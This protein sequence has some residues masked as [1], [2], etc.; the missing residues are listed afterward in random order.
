[1]AALRELAGGRSDLLAEVAGIFEGASEGELDEPL[2][3]QAAG[4]Y[5]KARGRSG[6]D[7]GW[8][9]EGWRRRDAAGR[10]SFSGGPHG[11]GTR[12]P[13]LGKVSGGRSSARSPALA[14]EVLQ[15]VGVRLPLHRPTRG[16]YRVVSGSHSLCTIGPCRASPD[17]KSAA[18]GAVPGRNHDLGHH[19]ALRPRR[20]PTDRYNNTIAKPVAFSNYAAVTPAAD[21]GRLSGLFPDGRAPMW[22]WCP[23]WDVNVREYRKVQVGD[24]VMLGRQGRYFP[25]GT[26]AYVLHNAELAEARGAGT[27]MIRP[28]NTCMRWTRSDP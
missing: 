19:A 14:A 7:T 25:C 5:R 13:G 21:F 24:L 1:V 16:A 8:I 28:G 27:S 11:G 3:R 20:A 23:E 12:P 6:G 10:A 4:L 17:L 2:V 18:D 15:E 9:A 22:G 26:V